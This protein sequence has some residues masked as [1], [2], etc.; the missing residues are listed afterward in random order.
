MACVPQ[1]PRRLVSC[2]A[3]SQGPRPARVGPGPALVWLQTGVDRSCKAEC[4][5]HYCPSAKLIVSRTQP[6]SPIRIRAARVWPMYS[7]KIVRPAPGPR[8][9]LRD[10][11]TSAALDLAAPGE[12]CHRNHE[13]SRGHSAHGGQII[14]HLLPLVPERRAR[15]GAAGRTAV[16]ADCRHLGA[17]F[18]RSR[19]RETP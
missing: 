3:L 9:R 6:P 7:T 5:F 12:G 8:L 18:A 11:H 16:S 2:C 14:C 13:H 17:V 19:L 15:S 1:R 10:P 4:C